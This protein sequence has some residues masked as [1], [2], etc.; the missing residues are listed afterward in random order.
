MK[1][2]NNFRDISDEELNNFIG[3][4]SWKSKFKGAWNQFH[5]GY[6]AGVH[7]RN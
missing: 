1:N 4:K 3:G 5:K 6:E 2:L 7:H